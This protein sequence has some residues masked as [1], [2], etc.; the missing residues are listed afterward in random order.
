MRTL[1]DDLEIDGVQMRRGDL[2][3]LW[4]RSG[5]R[6]EDVFDD[7]DLPRASGHGQAHLAFGH[8]PHYC[9]AAFLA[10]V[11]IQSLVRALAEEVSDAEL[12]GTPQRMES[13]FLRG[14]RS[15]PIAL[16]PRGGSGSPTPPPTSV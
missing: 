8:G 4:L 9:I 16:R 5:N 6:D 1:L 15:V 2:V 7:P 14:Y 11:E 3:T 13:N 12:A 10:R